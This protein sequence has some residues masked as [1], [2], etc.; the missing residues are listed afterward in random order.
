[1][2]I[3]AAV[4]KPVVDAILGIAKI[5]RGARV[6]ANAEKAIREAIRELL[7]ADPNEDAIAAKIAIAKAAG[8]L[9]HEVVLAETMLGKVRH[10][11]TT[12]KKTAKRAA[13]KAAKK[14]AKKAAKKVAKKRAAKKRA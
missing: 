13:K 11:R 1:M 5:G 8:I 7:Q 12:S 9:S 4:L 6:K 2:V 3:E 10:H 14:T